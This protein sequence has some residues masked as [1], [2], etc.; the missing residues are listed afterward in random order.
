MDGQINSALRYLT[1]D[2]CGGVLSLDVDVMKQL[3]EKHPKTQPAKL[4]SLLFGPVEEVHESAYNELTGEMI[5]KA[6][7]RTKGAGGPCNVDANGFQRILASKSFKKYASNMCDALA[8]LTRQLCTEY[9]D[10]ALGSRS[11]LEQ[12]VSGKVKEWME[13]V[14][15]LAEFALLHPQAC[16]AAFTYGLKHRWTYILRTLPDLEDLLAPQEQTTADVLIPSIT[17]HYCTQ[18]EQ[19]LA[20][21]VRMGGMG[22]TNPI[23][24]AASEYI[25]SANISGA[26]AQQIKSQVH[27][28][29]DKNEIHAVQREMRQVKNWYLNEKLD[30]VKS[31]IS[32]KTLRAV[33]LATQKGA[34]SWLTVLPIRDMNFALNKSEF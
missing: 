19:E 8:T 3:H 15:R 27:K 2:G 10:P 17:G 25:A 20:L 1:D 34:F 22:L 12:Y 23:L 6:G 28:P 11:Y 24:E 7:L 9:I 30:Q 4:E 5:R 14:T 21:P 26:L 18:E 16:Y 31:S 33:D 29:P 13:Q 32:G